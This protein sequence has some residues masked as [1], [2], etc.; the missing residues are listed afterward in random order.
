[1]YIIG[2]RIVI[3]L[4][5]TKLV[6]GMADLSLI[7]VMSSLIW[8]INIVL[9]SR[10]N[11]MQPFLTWNWLL[12]LLTTVISGR[13]LQEAVLDPQLLCILRTLHRQMVAKVRIGQKNELMDPVHQGC[14][15]LQLF[16][17]NFYINKVV[18]TLEGLCV[19]LPNFWTHLCQPFFMQT[20][21]FCC[22]Q[23]PWVWSTS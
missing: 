3:S 1:M 14:L 7:T 22:P 21:W 15:L 5:R 11:C 8:F 9:L 6:S 16:F 2:Q 12:I 19:F 4:P 20:K 13:N 23:L 10:E 17:F 18:T